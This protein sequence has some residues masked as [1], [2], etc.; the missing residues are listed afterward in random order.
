[1]EQYLP[2]LV[3]ALIGAGVSAIFKVP[4]AVAEWWRA[5]AKKKSEETELLFALK[6]ELL[7]NGGYSIK[8]QVNQTAKMSVEALDIARNGVKVAEEAH[9]QLREHVEW[10]LERA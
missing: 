5:R 2:V 10:H 4:G 6:R 8:D 3:A 1:M 9:R 7:T